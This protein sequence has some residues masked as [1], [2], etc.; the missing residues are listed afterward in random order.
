MR[1]PEQTPSRV[2]NGR[3]GRSHAFV[4]TAAGPKIPPDFH[5][6]NR[7]DY[8]SLPAKGRLAHICLTLANVGLPLVEAPRFSVVRKRL[9]VMGFSPGSSHL[10]RQRLPRARQTKQQHGIPD[11]L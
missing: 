10:L 1:D 8:S 6:V 2:P 11:H 3:K 7:R 9:T 5:L 4:S